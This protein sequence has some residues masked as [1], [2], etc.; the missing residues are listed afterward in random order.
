MINLRSICP[1][2]LLEKEATG[3]DLNEYKER[4]DPSARASDELY[5]KRLGIC[6]SCDRLNAGLCMACGC[7]V[8]L[9]AYKTDQMCPYE[10]W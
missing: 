6:Q 5:A 7:Y 10:K 1:R 9:R 3:I 8:E 2:C 4:V